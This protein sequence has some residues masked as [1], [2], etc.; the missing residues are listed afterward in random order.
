MG[1]VD[2]PAMSLRASGNVGSLCY[3]G[4]R[5]QFV[6]RGKSSL[7]CPMTT[8]QEKA[9]DA[10]G[11]AAQ[12]WGSTLTEAERKFWEEYAKSQR[13]INRLGLR[14]QPTG[15]QIYMKRSVSAILIGGS[16]QTT[17]PVT[18]P[19]VHPSSVTAVASSTLGEVDL[20]MTFIAGME[21]PEIM[22][23][24]RAGPFD[25]GGRKAQRPEYFEVKQVI[26]PY[27]WT[28]TGLTSGKYYWY[29]LRWAL[30]T[31][32]VSPEWRLQVLVT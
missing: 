31:G 30:L 24:F 18:D 12:G 26:S 11:A 21:Q 10:V 13:L 23:V 2:G 28:D 29:M 3:A 20:E 6:A 5:G 8:P 14:W 16:L 9:Q 32:I 17:P 19:G 27:Q 1:I 22:W 15:Y 4:W 7:I 25:S